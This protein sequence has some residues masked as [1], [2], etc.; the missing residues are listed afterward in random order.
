[1]KRIFLISITAFLLVS[2][3][4]KTE[5][6]TA[7]PE[8]QLNI[9]ILLDLSDRI[10]PQK[11]SAPS[12][13]ERDTANIGAIVRFFKS[14][15]VRLNAFKAKGK[16]RVFFSPAPANSQINDIAEELKI[17]CSKMDTKQKK[18]VYDSIDSLFKSNIQQIYEQT[19]SSSAWEGSDIWRFFKKDV[20][21]CIENDS[22]YRNILIIFTDGYL[23]HKNSKLAFGNNR[24]SYLLGSNL[25][26]YRKMNWENLIQSKD[27]GIKTERND[28]QN[29][30][31]L[32]LE[33][34]G[35]GNRQ[36]D[37]DILTSLWQK[38]LSEMN[39]GH[40]KVYSTDLPSNT[41]TRIDNFLMNH[42]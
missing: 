16:I 25:N 20:D 32:V 8:K 39:V 35:Y 29:L 42:Q 24:Y 40:Y 11:V 5:K 28:L 23:Y 21:L 1:M 26:P 12:P 4:A 14:E 33:V 18:N 7:T 15:M 31:V 41:S 34:N 3:G 9:S 19:I 36:F 22:N 27:F 38:W 30:E 2:C 10:S 17:D 13:M 6:T 37:D